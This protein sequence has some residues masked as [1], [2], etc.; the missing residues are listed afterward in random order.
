MHD[1]DTAMGDKFLAKQPSSNMFEATTL[2]PKLHNWNQQA[3]ATPTEA[4][5][6]DTL[7]GIKGGIY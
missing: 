5:L 2:E 4:Q 7:T 6:K 3:Q 1:N